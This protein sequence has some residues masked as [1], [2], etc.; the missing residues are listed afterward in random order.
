MKHLD[1]YI[2]GNF[3]TGNLL[4]VF[5][6]MKAIEKLIITVNMQRLNQN[7]GSGKYLRNCKILKY[8]ELDLNGF[9][10]DILEDI[11]LY[12]PNLTHFIL[13]THN[14]ILPE[15]T[16]HNLAKIDNLLH[17]D[18]LS[19]S[20]SDTEVCRLIENSVSIRR[21]I[22]RNINFIKIKTIQTLIERAIRNPRV[23]Y[24]LQ[25]E[26][27]FQNSQS[28]DLNY[29]SI[30]KNL[31]IRANQEIV[32]IN[33]IIVNFDYI[34]SLLKTFIKNNKRIKRC[35]KALNFIYS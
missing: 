7:Y 14:N 3:I 15:E 26:E 6:G 25:F 8:F 20:L 28:L 17:I 9:C 19:Y 27:K 18:I 13:K 23:R 30:P 29:N 5:Q 33:E 16:L 31:I 4:E 21:L 11:D 22:F 34:Y 24:L 10:N 1:I 12:L 32:T 2:N 35:K